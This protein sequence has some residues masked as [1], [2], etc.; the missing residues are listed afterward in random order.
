MLSVVLV[1][2]LGKAGYLIYTGTCHAA[3]VVR[4]IGTNP[5]RLLRTAAQVI[6]SH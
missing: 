1:R 5:P 3:V 2:M 6:V 4:A